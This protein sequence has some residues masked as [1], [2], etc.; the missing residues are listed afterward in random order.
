MNSY[1]LYIDG[2]PFYTVIFLSEVQ[3]SPH[4]SKNH[5]SILFKLFAISFST[6]NSDL[7]LLRKFG[8]IWDIL[9]QFTTINEVFP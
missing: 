4:L 8:S 1:N 7:I 5:L 3:N 2:N 6:S 9:F